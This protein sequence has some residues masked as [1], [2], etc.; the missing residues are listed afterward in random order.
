MFF[1]DED[2]SSI[3]VAFQYARRGNVGENGLEEEIFRVM[4]SFNGSDDW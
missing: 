1:G 4:V 3:D 2:E